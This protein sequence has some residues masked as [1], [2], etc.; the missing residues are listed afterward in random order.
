MA[1]ESFPISISSVLVTEQDASSVGAGL[2]AG[3]LGEGRRKQP[4]VGSCRG[5]GFEST[6]AP[7]MSL[8]LHWEICVRPLCSLIAGWRVSSVCQVSCCPPASGVG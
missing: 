6:P 3:W 2:S 1:L 4:L 5:E 7:P 8:F